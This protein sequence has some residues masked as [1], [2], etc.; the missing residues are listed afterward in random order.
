MNNIFILKFYREI[1]NILV[2]KHDTNKPLG[3]YG[4]RW[5]ND[6]KEVTKMWLRL[7]THGGLL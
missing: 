7:R 2:G 4:H 1:A 5:E 6:I 3:R